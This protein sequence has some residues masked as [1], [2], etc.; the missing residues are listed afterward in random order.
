MSNEGRGEE[1][2]TRVFE[3]RISSIRE[4]M[5]LYLLYVNINILILDVETLS[6]EYLLILE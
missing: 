5:L 4:A 3:K 6:A 2:V 1:T